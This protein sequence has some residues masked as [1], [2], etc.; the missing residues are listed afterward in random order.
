MWTRIPKPKQIEE[1]V[2]STKKFK[3]DPIVKDVDLHD[4][5][6]TL[7]GTRDSDQCEMSSNVKGLCK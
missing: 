1:M 7:L 5:I 6:V 2:L 4:Q 3:Y